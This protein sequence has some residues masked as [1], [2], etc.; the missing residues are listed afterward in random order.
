ML[1]NPCWSRFL[2]GDWRR[3]GSVAP[4]AHHCTG[5]RW[6]IAGNYGMIGRECMRGSG[7]DDGIAVKSLGRGILSWVDRP[8]ARST[9]LVLLAA[10]WPEPIVA[11]EHTHQGHTHQ[12]SAPPAYSDA[13][14]GRQL[15]DFALRD[16]EGV[17]HRLY[18][19]R[20]SPAVVIMTQGNGC[21]I[22]RNAMPVFSQVRDAYRERDV[23][24][25]LLNS[26]LQD[27]RE[28]V[29]REVREF[30][31]DIPVL[32]DQQQVVGEAFGVTRTAEIYLV[33]T[34]NWTVAYHG[35]VD[36]RLS[37]QVQR[38]QAR[39]SYLA[40]ALDAVLAGTPVPVTQVDAPGCIVNF[41][42]R[43]QR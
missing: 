36:D 26:N 14:V 5:A 7:W 21:P 29:A 23:V 15:D 37:Y 43:G 9:A 12:A 40:D 16:H 3:A 1:E 11:I 27:N 6:K 10:L 13:I 2:S 25:L 18:E 35:P 28:T 19:Y 38:A 31:W 34:R 32:L 8:G 41:P 30:G 4:L 22:V 33:D 20:D 24:F 39:H 17:L 42:G